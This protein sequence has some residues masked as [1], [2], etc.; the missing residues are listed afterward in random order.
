MDTDHGRE[1]K[2]MNKGT[3]KKYRKPGWNC[4]VRYKDQALIEF[5]VV[6]DVIANPVGNPTTELLKLT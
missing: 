5:L 3:A 2:K 1:E 4:N 6:I